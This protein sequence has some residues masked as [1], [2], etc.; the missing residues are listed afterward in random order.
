M[1]HEP[2]ANPSAGR[3]PLNR[4]T[5]LGK[6]VGSCDREEILMLADVCRFEGERHLTDALWYE[7]LAD[8]VAPREPTAKVFIDASPRLAPTSEEAGTGLN[9]LADS[10]LVRL[11]D[12][13]GPADHLSGYGELISAKAA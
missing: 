7:S 2:P 1:S 13:V 3:S 5:P 6:P 8:Q 12:D 9:D 10:G 4:M 11:T